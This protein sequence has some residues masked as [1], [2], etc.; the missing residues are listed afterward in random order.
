MGMLRQA[1]FDA[2]WSPAVTT[3][4]L[5]KIRGVVE[6]AGSWLGARLPIPVRECLFPSRQHRELSSLKEDRDPSGSMDVT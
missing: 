1:P 4:V 3:M 6:I 5:P 2:D